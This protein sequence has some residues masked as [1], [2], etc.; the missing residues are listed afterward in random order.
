MPINTLEKEQRG[1]IKL[2][3]RNKHYSRKGTI[4]F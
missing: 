1:A 3:L 2:V 4:N